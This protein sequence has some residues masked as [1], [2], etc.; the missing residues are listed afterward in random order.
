MLDD[1]EPGET[2]K[3]T[4]A[5]EMRVAYEVLGDRLPFSF[6][7]ELQVL[8]ALDN[9]TI[10]NPEYIA[11]EA[12]IFDPVVDRVAGS[13]LSQIYKCGG[14]VVTEWVVVSQRAWSCRVSTVEE[15][16][17]Q[18]SAVPNADAIRVI[19]WVEF[20]TK[21]S[22]RGAT[23]WRLLKRVMRDIERAE[24]GLPGL[25]LRRLVLYVNSQGVCSCLKEMMGSVQ[26]DT[27]VR[28]EFKEESQKPVDVEQA[29]VLP[30]DS[31]NTCLVQRQ[32]GRTRAHPA[33]QGG[34][35]KRGA[36]GGAKNCVDAFFAIIIDKG[37]DVHA[38]GQL[39]TRILLNAACGWDSTQHPQPTLPDLRLSIQC[40]TRRNVK[41][42][43]LAG[44]GRRDCGFVWN[45]ND[46]GT[47]TM[48]TDIQT[49]ADIIGKASGQNGSIECA[50]LN[51]CST[52]QLGERLKEG[53]MSHI[54]CWTIPVH[55]EAARELCGNFNRALMEQNKEGLL[56][57]GDYR[58]AFDAAV[59]AMRKQSVHEGM[60][61]CPDESMGT[62]LGTEIPMLRQQGGDAQSSQFQ[63]GPWQYEDVI[64]FLS[65]DG[66]SEP[67]NHWQ[68]RVQLYAPSDAASERERTGTT[69]PTII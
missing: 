39:M 47:A 36:V 15:D 56:H 19:A 65:K 68:K 30:Q 13:V 22:Q 24:G 29:M 33:A 27:F 28:F 31:V 2:V 44:H 59:D 7:S 46:A 61:Y 20:K 62:V 12:S 57:S 66:D 34:I 1:S 4:V 6:M 63:L 16:M 25:S 17:M 41:I 35:V 48:E 43:H 37:M 18:D 54:V 55:D 14:V 40:A 38:E 60:H 49:P 10:L 53:G 64:Q 51:A 23:D 26:P 67:I 9:S 52:K 21:P 5:A 11:L 45:A 3:Q 58:R 50:V 32:V 69:K 42:L 8:L